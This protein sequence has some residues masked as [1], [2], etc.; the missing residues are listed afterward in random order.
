[1]KFKNYYTKYPTMEKV[2]RAKKLQLA[3]W[4]HYL[5]PFQTREEHS[6]KNKIYERFE[7][8]GGWSA[9]IYKQMG[10]QGWK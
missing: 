7:E 6:I 8:K 10:W 4:I 3:K 5:P 2:K 1:M 9:S